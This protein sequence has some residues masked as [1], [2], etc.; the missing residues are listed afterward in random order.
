MKRGWQY[1]HTQT[2]ALY[3]VLFN[4][5]IDGRI[6]HRLQSLETGEIITLTDE[7]MIN[8]ERVSPVMERMKPRC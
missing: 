4:F 3:Q 7:Q 6:D 1:K 2:N 5:S 8:Y